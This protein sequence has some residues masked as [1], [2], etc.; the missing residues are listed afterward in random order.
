MGAPDV[1]LGDVTELSVLALLN[2]GILPEICRFRPLLYSFYRSFVSR[3]TP[4]VLA[5]E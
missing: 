5:A 2:I 4:G 1:R 3:Q